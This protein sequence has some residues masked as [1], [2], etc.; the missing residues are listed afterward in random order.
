MTIYA[1]SKVVSPENTIKYGNPALGSMPDPDHTLG[2]DATTSKGRGARTNT[3][4]VDENRRQHVGAGNNK[5]IQFGFLDFFNKIHLQY[6][7][8]D[9]GN[10]VS[11][12]NLSFFVF[13]AYF[14]PRT[15]NDVIEVGGDGLILTEPS[16]TPL[17]YLPFQQYVYQLSVSTDG[18]P[19]VDA[20]YTFDF[21]NRDYVLTVVG[22]RLVLFPYEPD[23]GVVEQLQWVSDVIE[24]YDGTEQRMS[25]RGAPR[26]R[27]EFDV[28]TE[29][30]SQ[31]TR[32]RSLIFD[33]MSRVYGL[34][35][36]WEM[37]R[38]NSEHLAGSGTLDVSTLYGDFRLGG[39]VMIY[40][41]EDTYEVIGI[42][43]MDSTSITL[44]SQ[45]VNSYT[46]KAVAMPVRTAYMAAQASRS[47]T[48]TNVTRTSVAF[49]T[50][51]NVNIAD[52]TGQTTYLG[53]VFLDDAN[54]MEDSLPESWEKR[55]TIIDAITG[56]QYQISG[57]DRA[58]MGMGKRWITRNSLQEV[59][60]VRRLLHYLDGN[61]RSFY[62]PSGRND[63]V[64]VQTIAA[65]TP[66]IRVEHCNF[67]SLYKNRQPF[68]NLRVVLK[69]GQTFT[70]AI[71]DSNVDGAF[72]VLSLSSPLL[73]TPI[74][75][76]DVERIEFVS[77]VRIRDDRAKLLHRRA[78]T[79]QVDI[80]VISCKE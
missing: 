60:R 47:R 77:L 78:G 13:N 72:E 48:P 66:T 8:V 7:S 68:S 36:W 58:R 31:D 25:L 28:F 40:Q 53:K 75:V 15:L 65:D 63:L 38:L 43:A 42:D 33:W 64:L 9:L 57:T 17:V 19:T 12:Q 11:T 23:D 1:G 4:P 61:R 5:S 39:L 50:I 21:D 54:Y 67:T 29:E 62:L 49:T 59:W 44:Q 26:Q 34:P 30:G 71:T 70:R 22:N 80:S 16:P 46:H 79:A 35:V 56:L 37:R 45:L 74:P 10:I 41:D 55:V 73:G 27:I 2:W 69:D 52:T 32:L 20:E 6:H 14:E 24:A 3:Q 18:P 51:E 76:E